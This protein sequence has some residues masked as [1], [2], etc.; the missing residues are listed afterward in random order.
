MTWTPES[1][2]G[3]YK[4]RMWMLIITA[5]ARKTKAQ[6]S[7]PTLWVSTGLFWYQGCTEDSFPVSRKVCLDAGNYVHDAI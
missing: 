1:S 7:K 5:P 2:M 3:P 6:D 4:D